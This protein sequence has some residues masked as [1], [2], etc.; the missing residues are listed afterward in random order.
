MAIVTGRREKRP[1][2]VAR[3][4]P[5]AWWQEFLS[6]MPWDA[7]WN[8]VGNEWINEQY[9]A[10]KTPEEAYEQCSTHLM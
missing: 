1:E 10:G 6:L 7:A 5:D 8:A 3:E 2:V 4:V 9:R